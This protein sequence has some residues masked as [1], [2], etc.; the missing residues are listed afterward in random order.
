MDWC[1]AVLAASCMLAVHNVSSAENYNGLGNLDVFT[2]E[3]DDF[4]LSEE[5]REYTTSYSRE[6]A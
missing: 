4:L 1:K 5:E 3:S 2:S 6:H